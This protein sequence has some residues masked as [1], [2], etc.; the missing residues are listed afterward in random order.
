MSIHGP[1]VHAIIAAQVAVK[2]IVS[3]YPATA[4]VPVHSVA[5]AVRDRIPQL[6]LSKEH[7]EEIVAEVSFGQARAVVFD[8]NE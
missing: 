2:E 6:S 1:N 7:L 8:G 5:G 3:T 4:P